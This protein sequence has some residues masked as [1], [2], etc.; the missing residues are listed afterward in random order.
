MLKAS[1]L[2]KLMS[3][4]LGFAHMLKFRRMSERAHVRMYI[5]LIMM[6]DSQT[7]IHY[8]THIVI[9]NIPFKIR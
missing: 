1:A 9:D 6:S 8:C 2:V 4:M 3:D 5:L 7:S